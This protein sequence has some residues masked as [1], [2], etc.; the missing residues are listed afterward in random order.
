MIIQ[1]VFSGKKNHTICPKESFDISYWWAR[2]YKSL[3]YYY[4]LEP[5]NETKKF[6]ERLAV[7][8]IYYRPKVNV[9]F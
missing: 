1:P 3:I 7:L 8:D 6:S 9:T 2:I 5:E 4:T